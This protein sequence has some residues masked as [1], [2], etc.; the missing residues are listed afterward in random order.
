MFVLI[1]LIEV[2]FK[3]DSRATFQKMTW[4]AFTKQQPLASILLL[5]LT[6]LTDAAFYFGIVHLSLR[7]ERWGFL[8]TVLSFAVVKACSFKGNLERIAAL[9]L[10][11]N[12]GIWCMVAT[13]VYGW[14]VGALLLGLTYMMI[15]FKEQ[16]R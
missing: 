14:L 7:E 1:G 8:L 12:V 15:S 3:I 4:L 2:V 10:F 13:I 5:L 11:L 9:L 16:H 6:T